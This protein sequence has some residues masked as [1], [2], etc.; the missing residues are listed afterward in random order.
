VSQNRD[1][2]IIKNQTRP[3]CTFSNQTKCPS[4]NR[5]LKADNQNKMIFNMAASW[6]KALLLLGMATAVYATPVMGIEVRHD[7]L[8]SP[9]DSCPR[10]I[11]LSFLWPFSYV[12][13]SHLLN[14]ELLIY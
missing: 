10:T 12:V 6:K 14:I 7:N 3:Y 2:L 5:E 13:F 1:L 8:T 11:G 4:Q 9:C